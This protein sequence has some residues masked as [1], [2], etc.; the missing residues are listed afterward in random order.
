MELVS[1][2]GALKFGFQFP[3][4]GP[5]GTRKAKMVAAARNVDDTLVE[6]M[7]RIFQAATKNGQ[8]VSLFLE[9]RGIETFATLKCSKL[10]GV[11]AEKQ[12]QRKK[13]VNPSQLRRSQA[14]MKRFVEKKEK[15]KQ[16]VE[17]E[18]IS[19]MKASGNT[20]LLDSADSAECS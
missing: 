8:R 17:E 6:E 13:P 18:Q 9:S 14:R 12:Q 10:L 7:L 3:V 2:F 1:C 20:E 16:K 5:H 4:S 15:E 11:P 19:S